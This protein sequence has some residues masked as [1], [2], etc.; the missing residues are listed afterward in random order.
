MDWEHL[1]RLEMKIHQAIDLIEQLK[2]ENRQLREENQK[3]LSESQSGELLIQQLKEENHNLKQIQNESSLGKEKED[4]IRTK[5]EQMLE[6][7]DELH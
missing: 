4:K 5:I 1:D 6:K 7:L 3:L 2:S